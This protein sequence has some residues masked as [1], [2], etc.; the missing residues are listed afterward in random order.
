[1]DPLSALAVGGG[2]GYNEHVGAVGAIVAQY[3]EEA[4]SA[5][6]GAPAP[7]LDDDR[8]GSPPDAGT[9]PAG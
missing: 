7:P 6:T 4:P 9:G 5:A 8:S 3:L 1:M 2:V